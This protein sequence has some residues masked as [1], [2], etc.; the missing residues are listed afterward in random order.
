MPRS[1]IK[2]VGPAAVCFV[3]LSLLAP[4]A[5]GQQVYLGVVAGGYANADFDARYIPQPGYTPTVFDSDSGG[6]VIGPSVDV[7]LF[8]RFSIGAEAL[9][10]PLH[11]RNAVT[12]SSEGAVLGFAPATVVTW[13]FPIL[14]RYRFSLGRLR[15]FL[16]GGPSFRT[17][18]NLN[19]S[20]PSHFGVTAGT[21]AEVIWR[22][23][24]IAP[25]I[26]Y[27]RWAEDTWPTGIRTRSD[28]VE[29]LTTFSYTPTSNARPLG[30]RISLGAVIGPD[31]SG[32]SETTTAINPDPP[33]GMPTTIRQTLRPARMV[34]GPLIGLS[35]SSRFSI[36]GN[37][38]ASSRV[39]ERTYVWPAKVRK[40][41]S[42]WAQPWEFP[43]LVK[44]RLTNRSLRPFLA[45]GISFRLPNGPG[46]NERSIYGFTVGGGL[47]LRE[48]WLR[49]SPNV[50]YTRW[51]PD[52][53]TPGSGESRNRLYVLVGVSL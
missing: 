47:E 40:D 49:I 46:G 35:M 24:T 31:L 39:I 43:A 25:K 20:D 12:F 44:Y 23:L 17:A 5:F 7:H 32:G 19:S 9:Y 45:S 14:A 22:T 8:P 18:G 53:M 13:Q 30:R 42:S 3:F 33:Y 21:G 38:I 50:R 41:S 6:Y 28:Q 1:D 29:F 48:K 11:Y 2:L 52:R 27:T 37:A 10:K 51:G 4:L 16:E 26:R 36:E 34:F 15:P